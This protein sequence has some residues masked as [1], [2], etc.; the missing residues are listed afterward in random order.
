[1][2]VLFP[3]EVDFYKKF[4][5]D[6]EFVGHP[7]LDELRP[8]LFDK[9]HISQLRAKFGI[10][11]QHKVLG[12]MPGSRSSELTHHLQ[13][14]LETAAELYKQVPNLKVLL[15]V[16]PNLNPDAVRSRIQN[17]TF[18]IQFV[19]A[20]PFDMVAMTDVILCASGTATLTVG[21]MEKPMAIM[22]KMKQS[23][24][25]LARFIMKMPKYFGLVNLIQNKP[26]SQEFFQESACPEKMVP[27]LKTLL[28]NEDAYKKQVLELQNLKQCLGAKGAT[29]KVSQII[30]G[31]K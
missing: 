20:D 26:V 2:L 15:L 21:L 24:V 28:M 25:F 9:N 7:L 12:L 6:V 4:G 31:A 29:Q 22:Y 5:V 27:Y 19:Q 17:W 16:A 30:L 14:Q 10:P 8:E 23:T 11:A 18:P 3:F 13:T 1:M